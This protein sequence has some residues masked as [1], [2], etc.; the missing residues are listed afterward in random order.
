MGISRPRISKNSEEA[1]KGS[2]LSLNDFSDEEDEA[3]L[4]DLKKHAN[5]FEPV[6]EALKRQEVSRE[7][8]K[9]RGLR[10]EFGAKVAV[11]NINVT[12][13]NGQIFALLGHNGAGKTTTIS[14]LTGLI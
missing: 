7:C 9:I 3:I 4:A 10:R 6:A 8:L 13:Y 5:E 11:D 2:L 1:Y 14:M 12:I